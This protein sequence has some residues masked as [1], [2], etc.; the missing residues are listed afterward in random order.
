MT[1]KKMTFE[2]ALAQLEAVVTQLEKGELPLD[3]AI[4]EFQTGIQLSKYCK[5]ALEQAEKK[6]SDLLVTYDEV[7]E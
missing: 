6:V 3:E 1:K 4:K 7:S 2:E 5:D